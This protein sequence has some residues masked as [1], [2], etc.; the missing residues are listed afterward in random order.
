M[1]AGALAGASSFLHAGMAVTLGIAA[2]AV[3]AGGA[4]FWLAQESRRLDQPATT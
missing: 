4:A 1:L 3:A 2:V